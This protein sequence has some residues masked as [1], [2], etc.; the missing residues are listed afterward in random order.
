MGED[1]R[2]C[3]PFSDVGIP[4]RKFSWSSVSKL[5]LSNPGGWQSPS[6]SAGGEEDEDDIESSGNEGIQE[7]C[8]KRLLDGKGTTDWDG[9]G[10]DGSSGGVGNT[11]FSTCVW[12]AA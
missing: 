10:G 5:P 8:D 2:P 11:L 3:K 9:G 12:R 6:S 7:L 4:Y 1:A